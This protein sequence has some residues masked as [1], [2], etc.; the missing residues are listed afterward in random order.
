MS[1][2]SQEK[3][4]HF[5]VLLRAAYPHLDPCEVRKVKDYIRQAEKFYKSKHYADAVAA[6]ENG[7]EYLREFIKLDLVRKGAENE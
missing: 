4:Q 7:I 5:N 2:N 1:V 6:I 3:M